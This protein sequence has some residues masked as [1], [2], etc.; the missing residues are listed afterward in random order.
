[1]GRRLVQGLGWVGEAV[2]D[3][4]EEEGAGEEVVEEARVAAEEGE[5]LKDT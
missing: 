3:C 5:E 4:W 1:M 2:E